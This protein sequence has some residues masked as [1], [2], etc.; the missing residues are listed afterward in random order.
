MDPSV[1]PALRVQLRA[2]RRRRAALGWV[3]AALPLALLAYTR[4]PWPSHVRAALLLVWVAAYAGLAT[5]V[6]WARCPG[7]RALFFVG[8]GLERVNPL[9][10]SCGG[11]GRALSE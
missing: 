1:T 5:W 9:R 11:C 7:C 2:L 6:A 4:A 3:F 10:T 8:P